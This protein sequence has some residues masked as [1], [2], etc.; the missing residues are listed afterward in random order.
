MIK[1]TWLELKVENF[2]TMDLSVMRV[3]AEYA[4]KDMAEV[5]HNNKVDEQCPVFIQ[6]E[7]GEVLTTD[8]DNLL[9]LYQWIE[10]KK[11][12]Q[13]MFFWRENFKTKPYMRNVI[14]ALQK[15]D[16]EISKLSYSDVDEQQEEAHVYG[17]PSVET[18]PVK[19]VVYTKYLV[20]Y[21]FNGLIKSNEY[22]DKMKAIDA[23]KQIL[24]HKLPCDVHGWNGTAWIKLVEANK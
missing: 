22:T 13:E 16:L 15:L 7:D 20:R 3:T 14:N 2:E 10:K 23:Y 5:V 24:S 1:V 6:Y 21:S 17:L 12:I 4:D 11:T 18:P 19:Q 8:P 9:P